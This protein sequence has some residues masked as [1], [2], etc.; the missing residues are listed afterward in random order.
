[1]FF[2]LSLKFF[3]YYFAL[4]IPVLVLFMRFQKST[5]LIV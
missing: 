2:L 4:K 1:M 5:L 3:F